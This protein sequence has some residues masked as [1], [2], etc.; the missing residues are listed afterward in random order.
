MLKVNRR[1]IFWKPPTHHRTKVLQK[2]SSCFLEKKI[3]IFS[4]LLSGFRCLYPS[5]TCLVEAMETLVQERL[6]VAKVLCNTF[7]V[8]QT[9]QKI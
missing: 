1:S 6:I 4:N 9:T 5:L 7:K 8:S 3:K 2:G